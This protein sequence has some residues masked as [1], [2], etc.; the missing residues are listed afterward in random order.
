MGTS[1]A[2]ISGQAE[3]AVGRTETRLRGQLKLLVPL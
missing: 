2:G 1:A 3:R